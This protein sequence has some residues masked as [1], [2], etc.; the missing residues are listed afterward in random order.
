[1]QIKSIVKVLFLSFLFFSCV[2]NASGRYYMQEGNSTKYS[3]ASEICENWR[4]YIQTIHDAGNPGGHTAI[5][6]VPNEN[7]YPSLK[8]FAGCTVNW[9]RDS[10]SL[11]YGINIVGGGC[12]DG[13]KPKPGL[14]NPA[15]PDG[16]VDSFFISTDSLSPPSL[17]C[18]KDQG[19]VLN[20]IN[21]ATGFKHQIEPEIVSNGAGQVSLELQ[22]ANGKSTLDPFWN[23][24][25]NKRIVNIDAT[26]PAMMRDKSGPYLQKTD[27]CV[28][29]WNEMKVRSTQTWAAGSTAVYSNG[30]CKVIKN[31]V[32]V[33]Y[34]PI[35]SS[36]PVDPADIPEAVQ[37]RRPNGSALEFQSMDGINFSPLNGDQGILKR[38][39][40]G[41]VMWRYLTKGGEIEEYSNSGKLLSVTA[42]NGVKQTLTYDATSGLL[43]QVQD[44]TGHKLIFAYTNSL[45]SSV[46]M[47]TNKTIA[48]T[49]NAAGLIT[50]VKHLDNTHRLYHYEDSRFPTYLTGITDERGVRYATW[51]YDAQ[52]RAITSQHAGGA[53]FGSLAYNADGS[54]TLTDTLGKQT[55]YRFDDIAG[56][57]R[58]TSVEGQ[59]TTN[60]VG[61]NKNYT[62]TPEGWVASKT[63]WNGNKTTYTYNT[64]G[65]EI[66]RT[67]A[68]GTVVAKTI[69]SEW[70][71]TLN[72][73]TKVTEPDKETT[74]NYDVNGLLLNQKTR[75]LVTQ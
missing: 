65:Q 18:S 15:E 56:A 67:E 36:D 54:T 70:H 47:D 3:T 16:C 61:A 68:S 4:Q 45:L 5:T 72:V 17:S 59:P 69:T 42:T 13:R 38:I 14:A 35:V 27:A 52:G 63:D 51:S 21:A 49:Y 44:S 33:K 39:N 25:Y 74:Y 34:L 8:D 12:L 71:S 22:Y 10:D 29:G 58:V 43:M 24:T 62:Y 28:S 11:F 66:S 48:Y 55:I 53:E 7:V 57:R 60:C 31:G 9:T 23:H 1:M 64:K 46:T 2:V 19:F 30:L 75:S 26:F 50:D 32:V 73:K 40:T 6:T 41:N 37:L 20:P